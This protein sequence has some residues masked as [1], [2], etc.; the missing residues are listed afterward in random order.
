M[1]DQLIQASRLAAVGELAAGVAHEV[2]NPLTA[3]LG[4]A[5]ILLEDIDAGG[6]PA[7]GRR[8]DPGCGAACSLDRPCP[9]R[10]RP[11]AS[12]HSSMPT[13]LAD[14]IARML[15]L[16]RFPLD[17]SGV[18]IRESHAELPLHRARSASDPAG[19]SSTYSRTPCRRC[20]TAA[21]SGREFDPRAPRQS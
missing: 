7:L 20:P 8:D 17:A 5:E 13:D 12:N 15:E 16:V 2:N 6:P 9:A 14:L 19:R 1:Q 3:V 21:R 10:L 18:I 4:F 11:A